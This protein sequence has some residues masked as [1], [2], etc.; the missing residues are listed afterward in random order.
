MVHKEVRKM[1]PVSVR[2][3]EALFRRLKVKAAEEGRTIQWLVNQ[4]LE[5]LLKAPATNR[6]A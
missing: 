6:K 5:Q 4:G 1:V 3:D 2:V